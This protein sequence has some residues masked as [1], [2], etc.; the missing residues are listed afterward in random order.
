MKNVE[1]IQFAA[2]DDLARAVAGRWLERLAAGAGAPHHVALSGGRITQRFFAEVVKQ[3]GAETAAPGG[4][5]SL[6]STVHFFWADERC[7]PPTDAESNFRLAQELL[8]QPLNIAGQQI[9]RVRGEEGPDVAAKLAEEEIRAVVRSNG[10]APFPQPV[11][12]LVL[13]GLGEDGHIASLFPREP[14]EMINDPAVCRAIRNSPKP[15]PDRVTL[16]YQ[17]I[18][19]AREVWMLASGAGKEAALRESL[20]PGG[21]TPFGRLLRLRSQTMVFTDISG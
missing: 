15:P 5:K 7:V 18:A 11:L 20:S 19:A 21:R 10:P 13:L 4:T 6:P 16:G 8:F 17:T 9:H 1:L 3:A 14:E 12:D 2:P